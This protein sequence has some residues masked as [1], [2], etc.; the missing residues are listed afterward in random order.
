M[1]HTDRFGLSAALVT[2]FDASGE[3]DIGRLTAHAL[4]CLERGCDSV[5]LF[6]TTGE[7]YGLSMR[8]RRAMAAALAQ[9]MPSGRRFMAGVM[10]SGYEDAAEQARAA[11]D[12]GAAGLLAAPPFY[13]KAM[14][15][16]GLYDWFARMFDRV[17]AVLKGVILY[18][19]PGQTAVPLSV[20]LIARL[21]RS[22]GGAIIGIK[23]SSG[24]MET[25]K[26]FLAAHGDLAV[27]IGDE[28]LLPTA[29]RLG[30]QGSICGLANFAPE[31]LVPVIHAGGAGESV[32]D[33]V[34]M[35][36]SYPVLPATKALVAHVS[37]DAAF[38]TVRPPLRPLDAGQKASLVA[39]FD[40]I[41]GAVA[42]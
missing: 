10:A 8:E 27:L 6:G 18:H 5:T 12:A 26:A 41:L 34:R 25:A 11:F 38:E 1:S 20:E 17:G 35:V 16:D 2:P 19:I 29:M 42:A 13:M 32:I 21:R 7:G 36:V 33:I 14:P 3:V 22:F 30:A 37:G 31:L 9:A 39:G 40:R 15:D 23:D 28:R 24:D 4:R